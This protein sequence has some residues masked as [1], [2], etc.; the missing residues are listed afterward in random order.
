MNRVQIERFVEST[1]PVSMG[2]AAIGSPLLNKIGNIGIELIIVFLLGSLLS[3]RKLLT[4]D[5]QP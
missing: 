5:P 2:I 1:I 3:I 4:Q